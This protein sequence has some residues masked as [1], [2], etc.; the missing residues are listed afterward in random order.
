MTAIF[1]GVR[2]APW[3]AVHGV[4]DLEKRGGSW[5]SAGPIILERGGSGNYGRSLVEGGTF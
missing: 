4:L 3:S 2:S 1:G 5:G